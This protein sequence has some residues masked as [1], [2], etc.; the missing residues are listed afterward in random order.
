MKEINYLLFTIHHN[1]NKFNISNKVKLHYSLGVFG[2][3][4][5]RHFLWHGNKF[6]Y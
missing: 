1:M 4:K 6:V 5:H 3:K 2:Q